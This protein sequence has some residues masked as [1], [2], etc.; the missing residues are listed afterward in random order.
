ME[1]SL[2][3]HESVR[4]AFDPKL[5]PVQIVVVTSQEDREMGAVGVAGSAVLNAEHLEVGLVVEALRLDEEVLASVVLPDATTI[6]A[7]SLRDGQMVLFLWE[8]LVGKS[9]KHVHFLATIIF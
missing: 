6:P 9:C 8:T 4:S 5:R 1:Q 3:H 2:L 7:A